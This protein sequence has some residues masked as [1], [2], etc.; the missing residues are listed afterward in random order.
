MPFYH[1]Q[2]LF[3][4]QSGSH[5][6]SPFISSL[7]FHHLNIT[8]LWCLLSPPNLTP[9]TWNGLFSLISTLII[10]FLTIPPLQNNA[11]TSQ[12]LLTP[13][14]INLPTPHFTLSSQP[15]HLSLLHPAIV[16]QPQSPVQSSSHPDPQTPNLCTS[17][18]QHSILPPLHPGP[19]HVPED[20]QGI[21]HSK[22]LMHCLTKFHEKFGYVVS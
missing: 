7:L 2:I 1:L 11:T 5:G 21:H 12:C 13:F 8:I 15:L 20:R 22:F 17:P 19:S 14:Q 9:A 3:Q 16:S 10:T 4:R 18:P 6:S